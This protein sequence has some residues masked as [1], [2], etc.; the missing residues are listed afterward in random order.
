MQPLSLSDNQKYFQTL[1]QDHHAWLVSWIFSHV[2]ENH[3]AEDLAQNT[4]LRLLARIFHE[5]LHLTTKGTAFLK[6]ILS[7]DI[8]VCQT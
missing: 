4:F 5:Q 7:P 1:Y 3:D 6:K 2:K 8:S